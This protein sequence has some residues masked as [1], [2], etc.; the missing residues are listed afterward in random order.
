MVRSYG[1]SKDCSGCRYWSEMIAKFDGGPGIEAVCL[2]SRS[3]KNGRFTFEHDSCPAWRSGH[4]GA[5]D[6]P[7]NYGK[8]TQALYAKEEVRAPDG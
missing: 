4:H 3:T 7:P 5:V 6:T 8:A 2:N 1:E